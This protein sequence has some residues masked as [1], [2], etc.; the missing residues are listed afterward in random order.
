[1]VFCWLVLRITRIGCWLAV[2]YE[3]LEVAM[4]KSVDVL[5]DRAER[6]LSGCCYAEYTATA[7]RRPWRRFACWCHE[8]GIVCPSREDGDRCAEAA[9]WGWDSEARRGVMGRRAINGLFDVDEHGGFTRKPRSRVTPPVSWAWLVDEYVHLV[10]SRGL[11]RSTVAAKR[12][13][14][15]RFTVFL[16][17]C[18]VGA[19]DGLTSAVVHGF[20]ATIHGCMTTNY[21][22]FLRG[23]L[24]FVV[25]THDAD[26]VLK[27]LFPVIHGHREAALPSV[28]TADEVRRVIDATTD[29]VT[30]L[31]TRAVVLLAVLLGMRIGDIRALQMP[32]INWRGRTVSFI[33]EK[34]GARTCLPLPDEAMFALMDYLRNERPASGDPHVFL[35]TRAPFTGLAAGSGFQHIIADCFIRAG[36]DINAR[37]HGPHALR[38]AAATTMLSTGTGY[39]VIAGVLGHASTDTTRRYLRV[40]VDALR[41]MSLEVPDHD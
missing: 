10:E 40:D 33:Q 22:Y 7:Y 8:E 20:M 24:R 12:T 11:S 19:L 32:H 16:H 2:L 25:D 1:M 14:L 18:G 9:G 5:V 38:H 31:R 23:F 15:T 29:G 30:P 6:Y 27:G 4:P 28:Y 39:P 3:L 17:E 37:H 21:L 36:V 35:R 26:P 34:T 41:A 13:M